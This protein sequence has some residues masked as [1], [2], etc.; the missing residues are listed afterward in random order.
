MLLLLLRTSEFVVVAGCIQSAICIR[1][2]GAGRTAAAG[3]PAGRPTGGDF[4]NNSLAPELVRQAC[5]SRAICC[6]ADLKLL[7][8]FPAAASLI[9]G[10]G[11]V[12]DSSGRPGERRQIVFVAVPYEDRHKKT[13][14]WATRRTSTRDR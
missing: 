5:T 8:S 11:F 6:F 10:D 3:R 4:D 2:R 9:N 12:G 14:A 13:D 1:P 7:P